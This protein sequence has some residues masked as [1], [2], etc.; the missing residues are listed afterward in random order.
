MTLGD[1]T[2]AFVSDGMQISIPLS[3]LGNDDGQMGFRVL[4][5]SYDGVRKDLGGVDLAPNDGLPAAH[6]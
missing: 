4:S 3:M 6:T 5:A 1:V 2:P